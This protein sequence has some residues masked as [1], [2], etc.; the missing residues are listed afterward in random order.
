MRIRGWQWSLIAVFALLLLLA[1][2]LFK[3][4]LSL[5]YGD[6]FKEH[7]VTDVNGASISRGNLRVNIE[8]L[9]FTNIVYEWCPSEGL[10]SWCVEIDAESAELQGVVKPRPSNLTVND[11]VIDRLSPTLLGL[12]TLV[13]DSDIRGQVE[14]L[15]LASFDCPLQSIEDVSAAFQA[16]SRLG[17]LQLNATSVGKKID[18][19]ILGDALEG[20]AEIEGGAYEASGELTAKTGPLQIMASSL[21]TSLG[22][23]RYGWKTGGNIPCWPA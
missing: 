22:E 20:A 21:M 5:F 19:S 18:V 11:A 3:L 12:V 16:D 17:A 10:G 8:R 13:V 2:S 1:Y 7:G 15:H 6:L 9:G 23:N 4:P 14:S